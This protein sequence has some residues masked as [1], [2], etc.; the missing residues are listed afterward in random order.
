M[1]RSEINKQ[2]KKV[3]VTSICGKN[4]NNYINYAKFKT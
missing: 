2:K 4:N 3:K 1:K